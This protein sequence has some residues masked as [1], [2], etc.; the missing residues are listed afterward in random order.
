MHSESGAEVYTTSFTL[1]IGGDERKEELEVHS[2]SPLQQ[3]THLNMNA[4]LCDPSQPSPPVLNTATEV[5]YGNR[6]VTGHHSNPPSSSKHICPF[7]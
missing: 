1:A 7:N 3:E 4:I 2:R 6:L 5:D